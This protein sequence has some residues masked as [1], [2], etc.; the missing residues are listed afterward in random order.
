MNAKLLL[1]SLLV[2]L[3]LQGLPAAA[4]SLAFSSGDKR[5][6]LLELFTSQGCSSCPPA[7]TWINRFAKDGRLWERFIPVAFHV[8]YWDYL[9][10]KDPFSASLFSR[11]QQTYR[12]EG[13]VRAVYTP[14]FVL[15]GQELRSWYRQPP[16]F[17]D[18]PAPVLQLEV[19][20]Q[21]VTAKLDQAAREPL[22]LN[23]ALLGFDI[24]TQIKAGE[25]GGR[26]L[27]QE[28]VVLGF[29][30]YR[31]SDGQWQAKIPSPGGHQAGRYALVA[32]V[33]PTNNQRP[34]Q[35]TGGWLPREM[36]LSR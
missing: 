15:N 23:L 22:R 29:D 8:D 21:G 35:A 13:G 18:E 36:L 34:I 33:S 25:N 17:P 20:P 26:R 28:F 30:S 14:G 5:V 10:W 9:G 27:D 7:E 19:G 16:Q 32:W 6:H 11:R 3:L 1:R 4:D 12:K 24:K 31:S 2:L